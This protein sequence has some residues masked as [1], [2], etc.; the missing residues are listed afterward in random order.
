MLFAP[1]EFRCDGGG[2]LSW[3]QVPLRISP[4]GTMEVAADTMPVGWFAQPT[5]KG[6]RA[7]CPACQTAAREK[8][9]ADAAKVVDESVGP[10]AAQVKK[11]NGKKPG[12]M[13]VVRPGGAKH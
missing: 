3:C 13:K 1:I 4:L 8:A 6:W 12:L 11:I 2:C 7:V 10:A 5:D 9:Q